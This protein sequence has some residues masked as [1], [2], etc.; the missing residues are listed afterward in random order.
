MTFGKWR[1]WC[2]VRLRTL[3]YP[4]RSPFDLPVLPRIRLMLSV[5][6]IS[7]ASLPL[8][9]MLRIAFAPLLSAPIGGLAA[10]SSFAIRGALRGKS[11]LTY[12]LWGSRRSLRRQRLPDD[13][14]QHSE[15]GQ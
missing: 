6:P 12:L 7:D 13:S 9:P 14:V 8:L 4:A 2:A 11:S 15:G 10:D 3:T 5:K 1:H